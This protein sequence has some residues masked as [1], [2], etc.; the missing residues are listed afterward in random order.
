MRHRGPESNSDTESCFVMQFR[1]SL[2][3]LGW[4]D[5]EAI[6]FPTLPKA[7]KKFV[8]ANRFGKEV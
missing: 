6:S 5:W 3:A 4:W 8:A 1:L 2:L 7:E